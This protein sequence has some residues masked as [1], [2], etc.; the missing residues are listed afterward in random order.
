MLLGLFRGMARPDE[1]PFLV[2]ALAGFPKYNYTLRGIWQYGTPREAAQMAESAMRDV[3][4]A[5]EFSENYNQS[6]P[7]TVNGVIPSV[8][9]AAQ[10]IDGVLWRNGVPPLDSLLT[11]ATIPGGN[12]VRN[13]RVRG[14]PVDIVLDVPAGIVEMQG[15][16]LIHLQ[17]PATA[18]PVP[19]ATGDPHW[20]IERLSPGRSLSFSAIAGG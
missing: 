1:I 4:L 15:V 6:F 10:I 20:R 2:P 11:V 8:F 7:P 17:R 14:E 19:A 18:L 12:G 16:G 5:G 9:G 13:Y 3:T